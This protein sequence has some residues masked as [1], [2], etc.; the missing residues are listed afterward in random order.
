MA[1]FILASIV[2]VG[3]AYPLYVIA[4]A[5]TEIAAR[6]VTEG[7][8]WHGLILRLEEINSTLRGISYDI[9]GEI[10]ADERESLGEADRRP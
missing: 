2:A 7:P 9:A 4:D 10:E 8:P 5:L 1:W 3:L 6:R